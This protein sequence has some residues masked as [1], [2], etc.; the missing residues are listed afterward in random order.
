MYMLNQQ[1]LFYEDNKLATKG[2]VL[3]LQYL[4]YECDLYAMIYSSQTKMQQYIT[5]P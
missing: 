3:N 5:T 2:V 4:S 1:Y